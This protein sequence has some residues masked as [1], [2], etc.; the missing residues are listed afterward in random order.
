LGPRGNDRT[1]GSW[2]EALHQGRRP[3]DLLDT[4]ASDDVADPMG[5]GLTATRVTAV[6]IADLTGRLAALIGPAPS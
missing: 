4:S 1:L 2:V 6:T 3:E 5:E